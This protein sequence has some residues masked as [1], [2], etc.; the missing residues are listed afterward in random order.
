VSVSRSGNDLT[1]RV[2]GDAGIQ[3]ADALSDSLLPSVALRPE[4]VTLDLKELRSIS[5]LA[6]GVLTSY[7]RGVVRGGGRVRLIASLQP[8]VHEALA[9]AELLGLFETAADTGKNSE[10]PAVA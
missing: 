4:V 1:V 3:C 9:R 10:A 7:R 5:C 8:A 2:S 6:M